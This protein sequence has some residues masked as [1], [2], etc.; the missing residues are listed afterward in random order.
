MKF[1]K[2]ILAFTVSVL[3]ILNINMAEAAVSKGKPAP[4]FALRSM[5]GENLRL[6]EL[7]GKVVM[8]NFWATWCA[9]CRKEMPLLNDL[10]KK[11]KQSGFVLLGV[12]IDNNPKKAEKMAKKL[13]VSF[14]VL[15]DS[16]KTVSESY[17]V[18][19]MPF[20]VIIDKSGSVKHVHKG[21]L[22]GYEKKYDKQ[23]SKLLGN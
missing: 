11:H 1:N 2:I 14:P 8:V 12:N 4:D 13:G 22:P 9:P 20:T 17:G 6:S 10:Y 19:A 18:S 5:A 3:M 7:R 23:I 16:K 15:F 21:Y